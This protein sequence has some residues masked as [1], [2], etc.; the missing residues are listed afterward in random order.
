MSRI[1]VSGSMVYDTVMNYP[2]HFKDHILPDKIHVLNVAF[3][4]D[5]LQ[6]RF[7]GTA[8]NIAYNLSLLGL[9]PR[10]L[11]TV[12][13]DF[14]EYA[15]WLKQN[16]IDDSLIKI[17][18]EEY[19]AQ[20][21]I[22]T[23]KDDNQITAF[24]A[25][26]MNE[27]HQLSLYDIAE[28]PEIMIVS[29]NDVQAM[30]KY[31]KE[32]KELKIKVIFDPGQQIPAFAEEDLRICVELADVIITNDYEY[33]LLLDRTKLTPMD[34]LEGSEA[35]IVTN[36]NQGS[37]IHTEEKSYNIPAFSPSKIV[38]PTGCGDAYRAGI[39]YGML[40]KLPWGLSGRIASLLASHKIAHSGGQT[41]RLSLDEFK[42]DFK[43][44]VGQEF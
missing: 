21:Y 40:A 10:I 14:W 19:T 34:L 22:M 41:H 35:V 44:R 2:G 30:K 5:N 23:D 9:S 20:A 16:K 27:A 33:Q 32:A 17:H 29:P 36:G 11:S 3:L 12:G 25:G 31:V 24:L 8:G 37:V 15:D 43:K 6:K 4:V 42:A 7:G 13:R 28:K 38:D 1:L 39:V 18:N 26:A